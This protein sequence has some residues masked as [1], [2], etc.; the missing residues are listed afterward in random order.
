MDD[1][2]LEPSTFKVENEWMLCV[3]LVELRWVPI[4]LVGKRVLFLHL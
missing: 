3:E 2:G 4:L 1:A